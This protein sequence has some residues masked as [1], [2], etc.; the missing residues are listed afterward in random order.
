MNKAY[1]TI[2]DANDKSAWYEYLLHTCGLS[3]GP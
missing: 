3:G 2:S 1:Y